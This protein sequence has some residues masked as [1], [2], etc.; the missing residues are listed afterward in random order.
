MTFPSTCFL[1]TGISL[2]MKWTESM[3]ARTGVMSLRLKRDIDTNIMRVLG[4]HWQHFTGKCDMWL[5]MLSF[6]KKNLYLCVQNEI[7]S[8]YLYIIT[9]V[10]LLFVPFNKLGCVLTPRVLKE[11]A[12]TLA[13]LLV[14]RLRANGN[15]WFCLPC[16]SYW[17][18]C[19]FMSI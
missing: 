11:C 10:F 12:C 14:P 4:Q 17:C 13:E 7:L 9:E 2:T 18:T 1:D 3:Q 5:F 15:S 19:W 8:L 6:S 16:G